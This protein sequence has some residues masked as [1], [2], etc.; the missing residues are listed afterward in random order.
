[1]MG[2]VLVFVGG[3][4]GSLARYGLG[5]GLNAWMPYFPVGTFAANVLACLVVGFVAGLVAGRWNVSEQVRLGVVTGFCGG[6]STFST[7]SLEGWELLNGEKPMWG[8]V[9]VGVSVV[10]CLVGVGLGQWVGKVVSSQ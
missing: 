3:G 5:K 6:F 2:V 10:C 9:Y 7:F 4:L 8:L 1:M